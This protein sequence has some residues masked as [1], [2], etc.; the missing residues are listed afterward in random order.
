MKVWKTN[1]PSTATTVLKTGNSLSVVVP[2]KFTKK[3]GIRPGDKVSFSLNEKSGQI[4]YTFLN[5]R[6]LSLV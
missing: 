1:M 5:V 2:A 6:Q 3:L 4:T